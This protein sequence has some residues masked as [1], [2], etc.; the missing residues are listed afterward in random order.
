MSEYDPR[1]ANSNNKYLSTTRMSP[2]ECNH[3]SAEIIMVQYSTKEGPLKWAPLDPAICKRP[4]G[5]EE[6]LFDVR[7]Y[8]SQKPGGVFYFRRH[9]CEEGK[10]VY[11]EK[12]A[13]S[14][15]LAA[16]TIETAPLTR[17]EL[18]KDVADVAKFEDDDIPF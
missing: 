2:T 10:R 16:A 6:W 14:E 15:K 5:S 7:G 13:E 17:S 11:A 8:W 12:K 4:E 3:C 1:K 18:A 9:E